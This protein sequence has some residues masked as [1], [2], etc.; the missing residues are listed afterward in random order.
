MSDGLN[1]DQIGFQVT[2]S[3]LITIADEVA[4]TLERTAFSNVVRDNHDY[5]CAL[6]DSDGE[7][8]VQATTSTPGQLGSMTRVIKDIMVEY[9]PS[10]LNPGD[11]VITNDPW[12]GSGHTPDIYIVTPIFL[13]GSLVGFSVN[14]AH[15]IDIGGRLASPDARQVYEEGIILPPMKLY[16][17]GRENG[18]LFRLLRRNVRVSD[19]VIG[20]I[21]AQLAANHVGSDRICELM[22]ERGF[23]SLAGLSRRIFEQTEAALRSAIGEIPDGVYRHTLSLGQVDPAGKPLIMAVSLTVEGDSI[24][25]DFTGTSDQID[26]PVNCV[27]NITYAYTMYALKAALCP[28]APNN[29]GAMLP[30]T[31]IAPEGSLLNATYPVAVMWRTDVVYFVVEAIFGALEEVL[32]NNVMAGS[33]TYPLWLTIFSGKFDDGRAFVSH[34]NASGGQ[35]GRNASD[36]RSTLVFPG[37]IAN[38]PV[39]ILEVETPLLCEEKAFIPGSGGAG[40]HRGGLGQRAT[41]RNIS[42]SEVWATVVGGR[43]SEPPAGFAGGGSGSLGAV[44]LNDDPPLK[45]SAEI[46]L[47]PGDRLHFNLPGGGGFGD[48]AQRDPEA[49]LSDVRQGIVTEDEAARLYQVTIRD[50]AV[51]AAATAR[52]RGGG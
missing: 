45:K 29:A 2:W 10:E 15:H 22:R 7:M 47:G 51:D 52:L 16:D 17:E 50:G 35:G 30:I 31:L 48:P 19:K 34:F 12:L 41:I 27:Y 42:E 9:P 43:F 37:N 1:L 44:Q 26:R 32:P 6:Y 21:R 4:T 20:D 40:R 49:V 25:V 3:R 38:T 36:G 11:I 28:E 5:A 8:L 14:S 13:D 39:E 18:D 33:G 24:E 46:R 23:R